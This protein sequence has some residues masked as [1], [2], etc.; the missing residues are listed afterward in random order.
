MPTE[1]HRSTHWR[2][3]ASMVVVPCSSSMPSQIFVSTDRCPR[4]PSK[5][6]PVRLCARTVVI[7]LVA[8]QPPFI[9]VQ[10]LL[11]SYPRLVTT[12]TGLCNNMPRQ[13]CHDWQE[14]AHP[15][16]LHFLIALHTYIL[17][18]QKCRAEPSQRVRSPQVPVAAPPHLSELIPALKKRKF[19]FKVV[20]C[21]HHENY[22]RCQSQTS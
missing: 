11:C 20:G 2:T 9:G 22:G 3:L 21:R 17:G 18:K 4:I 16:Q 7:I 15:G 6:F 8:K 5:C 19:S 13:V 1:E 14:Y 12:S 10:G